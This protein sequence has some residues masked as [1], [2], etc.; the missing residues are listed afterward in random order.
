MLKKRKV[1]IKKSIFSKKSKVS[2]KKTPAVKKSKS[3]FKRKASVKKTPAVKKSKSIF[4]RKASVKKTPAVKKS[5]SIFKKT[6]KKKKKSIKKD[7]IRCKKCNR[8][9]GLNQE[10]GIWHQENELCED[11]DSERPYITCDGCGDGIAF[12]DAY[13]YNKNFCKECND[14]EFINKKVVIKL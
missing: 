1:N 4:K 2:V 11:C 10:H 8:Y 3:I 14:N 7:V 9:I 5:K 13:G 6:P 12:E